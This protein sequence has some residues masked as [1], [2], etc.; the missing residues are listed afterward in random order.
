MGHLDMP[1]MVATRTIT[2]L[3]G[4]DKTRTF[5]KG[6]GIGSRFKH[7]NHPCIQWKFLSVLTSTA[8][9]PCHHLLGPFFGS[10]HPYDEMQLLLRQNRLMARTR[11]LCHCHYQCNCCYCVIHRISYY[12]YYLY[13]LHIIVVIISVSANSWDT[14]LSPPSAPC[15]NKTHNVH[16]CCTIVNI[17]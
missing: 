11:T 7:Y 4:Y 12:H 1:F 9:S 2:L 17:V 13:M 3:R 10:F 8:Y 16:V 5:D 15:Q 14:S 6:N